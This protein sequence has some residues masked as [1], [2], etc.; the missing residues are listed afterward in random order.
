VLIFLAS[1]IT[2]PDRRTTEMLELQDFQISH[3]RESSKSGAK[4]FGLSLL[5]KGLY[6][7]HRRLPTR[8]LQTIRRSWFGGGTF[9]AIGSV[10]FRERHR[11][12][13]KS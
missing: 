8:S 12:T 7:R 6:R 11:T 1:E 10:G 5:Q 3:P 4:Y 9:L 13:M 2:R